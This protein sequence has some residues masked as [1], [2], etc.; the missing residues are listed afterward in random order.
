MDPVA[1][2]RIPARTGPGDPVP[3][4]G[5]VRVVAWRAGEVLALPGV[6]AVA[7]ALADPG[8]R[9]WVD[10]AGPTSEEVLAVAAHLRLHPLVAEDIVER[11][12][13]A[14]VEEIEGDLHLVLFALGLRDRDVEEVELDLVLGPR[15]LLSVHPP[16]WDPAALPML[17]AGPGHLLARG[18]D[19]LLYAIADGVVDGYFPVMD[20]LGDELDDLQDRVIAHPVPQTLERLFALKRQLVALRRAIG[21]AREI[22][23]TLTTRDLDLVAPEHV[24]YFRDVYDH[25]IRAAD[26]LDNDRELASATL[27]VYLSTVNNT[28][29]S[30]MKRL[31]GVTVVLAG[32]GAVAGVFG[33]SEAGLALAGGEAVGFWAVTGLIVG[34]AALTVT[35]LRRMDWI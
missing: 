4:A 16:G 8:T 9:V 13:R 23:N 31:T 5:R 24:L 21:P 1:D 2:P 19:F 33:M 25:L 27:E 34:A 28:L 29:S 30:I 6:D 35:V 7:D 18:A 17:R 3:A 10:L 11:N 12:Q 26:E 20:A 32:I 15:T 14:K 22:F